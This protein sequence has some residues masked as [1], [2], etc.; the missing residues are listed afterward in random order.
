MTP[1]H[2]NPIDKITPVIY[3][4]HVYEAIYEKSDIGRGSY[5]IK[6]CNTG[7]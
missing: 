1:L 3:Q 6:L 4:T 5:I 7:R 2:D